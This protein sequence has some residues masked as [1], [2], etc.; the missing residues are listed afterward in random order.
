MHLVGLTTWL[1]SFIIIII[2]FSCI[3]S[4]WTCVFL[5]LHVDFNTSNITLYATFPNT[6]HYWC[7][8]FV[9]IMDNGLCSIFKW[10]SMWETNLRLVWLFYSLFNIFILV[11]S[12]KCYEKMF[13]MI[14]KH[15][16]MDFKT[17]RIEDSH[18]HSFTFLSS[19]MFIVLN[20]HAYTPTIGFNIQH[21]IRKDI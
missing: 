1:L 10:K 6:H 4:F 7:S 3:H 8:L 18:S 11:E 2:F 19:F 17:K 16:L 12:R 5:H 21:N 15:D 20:F 13:L 14:P 9:L